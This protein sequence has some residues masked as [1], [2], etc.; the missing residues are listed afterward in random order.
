MT[1]TFEKLKAILVREQGFRKDRKEWVKDEMTGHTTLAWVIYERAAMC[2]AVNE[3][4]HVA[5]KAPV[6]MRDVYRKELQAEGHV[7]YTQKFAYGCAE[8]VELP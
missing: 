1:T 3:L 5:G 8:L 6:S 4:R 7:D 2:N